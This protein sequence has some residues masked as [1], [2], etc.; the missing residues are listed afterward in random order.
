[1]ADDETLILRSAAELLRYERP[2][3]LV[4]RPVS[5]FQLCALLQLAL[6]HPGTVGENQRAA[7]TFIEHVRA[8]FADAPAVLEMLRRG[9]DPAY[10][11]PTVRTP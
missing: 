5:A 10:D 1:M 8:Y 9:D 2:I 6:R 3:E 11:V 7:I 4:L